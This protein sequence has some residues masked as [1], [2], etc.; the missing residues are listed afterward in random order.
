MGSTDQH[1]GEWECLGKVVAAAGT[2]KLPMSY[3]VPNFG[4]YLDTLKK[5]T[6]SLSH[7]TWANR[8]DKNVN[9]S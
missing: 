9:S 5:E 3:F 2:P 8:G 4:K 1:G 7:V 6:L